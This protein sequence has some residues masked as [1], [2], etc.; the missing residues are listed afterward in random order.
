MA[1]NTPSFLFFLIIFVSTLPFQSLSWNRDSD[2]QKWVSWN[3]G[4]HKKKTSTNKKLEIGSRK[5]DWEALDE[6]LRIAEKTKVKVTVRKDGRGDYRRIRDAIDSIPEQNTKRVVIEIGP[7]LY[8]EKIVILRSKPFVTFLG[9]VENPPTITGNRTAGELGKDGKQLKTYKS[10]TVAINSDYFL[11]V[12]MKF[13]NTAPIPVPGTIGGQAVALRISGSKAAFYNCSFYGA[14]DTLYD[15]KGLHYFNNCFIQGSMDFIFGYGRSF[16]ESCHIRSIAQNQGSITAQKRTN[17]S[18]ASGFAF[19]KSVI[20]GSGA[21]YLGRAW[22]DHSRVI[23][24]YTYMDKLV[25][26][27]G[28]NNWGIEQREWTVYYGEYR[29]GGPGANAT[30]R[31]NWARQLTDEEAQPFLGSYFVDAEHWLVLPQTAF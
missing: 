8:R 7:G 30:G 13:E 10:A 15:H 17:A 25:L 14:Q 22:G 19:T 27:E 31:V 5:G 24:S 1:S 26:P 29:C 9:D 11:A 21:V 23:Y 12:N 3:V 28:W 18:L 16:Y 20:E 4:N 2:Y 6:K